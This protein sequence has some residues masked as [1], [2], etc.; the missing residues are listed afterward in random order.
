MTDSFF[1][2]TLDVCCGTEPAGMDGSGCFPFEG[3]PT[4]KLAVG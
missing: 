4:E 3:K 2:G 1:W